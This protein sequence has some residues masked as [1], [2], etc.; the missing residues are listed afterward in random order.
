M[1]RQKKW[2]KE[3]TI[4]LSVFTSGLFILSMFLFLS[5]G[6]KDSGKKGLARRWLDGV[7]EMKERYSRTDEVVNYFS[8]KW[9]AISFDVMADH[10][11]TFYQEGKKKDK[12]WPFG[13]SSRPFEEQE[14]KAREIFYDRYGISPPQYF[15]PAVDAYGSLVPWASGVNRLHWENILEKAGIN[16]LGDA[17]EY[18]DKWRKIKNQQDIKENRAKKLAKKYNIVIWEARNLVEIIDVLNVFKYEMSR[19]GNA[20]EFVAMNRFSHPCWLDLM[21]Q[22]E[23]IKS[24]LN[25]SVI[26]WRLTQSGHQSFEKKNLDDFALE[27]LTS[28]YHPQGNLAGPKIRGKYHG[29][30]RVLKTGWETDRDYDV[31]NKTGYN[32]GQWIDIEVIEG[33]VFFNKPYY[34]GEV[35]K[36]IWSY[37]GD[38]G[39]VGKPEKGDLVG[40]REV[41]PCLFWEKIEKNKNP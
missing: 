14:R 39:I 33:V 17:M 27:I 36:G 3:K 11:L 8:F 22:L 21:E 6:D 12:P 29:I 2:L 9:H 5:C 31:D 30:A 28:G 7:K 13:K 41:L 18:V 35:I 15:P 32:T 20:G 4:F 19:S 24:R 40:Y 16:N 34:P 26:E 1:I 23:L 38:T 37:G 25:D 10:T